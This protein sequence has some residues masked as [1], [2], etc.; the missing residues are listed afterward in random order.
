[1]L[2]YFPYYTIELG[3]FTIKLWHI[4][5]YRKVELRQFTMRLYITFNVSFS[6]PDDDFCLQ[7]R[8]IKISNR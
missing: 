1:M 7:L 3:Q 4:Y 5:S 2:A 8:K 6:I